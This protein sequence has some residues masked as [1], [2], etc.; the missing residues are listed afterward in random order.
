MLHKLK[1]KS[2]NLNEQPKQALATTETMVAVA[3][4]NAP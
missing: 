2:K 4:T 3:A 1:P